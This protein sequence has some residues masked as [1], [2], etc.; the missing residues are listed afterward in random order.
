MKLSPEAQRIGQGEGQVISV[1]WNWV[2]IFGNGQCQSGTQRVVHLQESMVTE[3]YLP[4]ETLMSCNGQVPLAQEAVL[5]G[6]DPGRLNLKDSEP[7]IVFMGPI[8]T[9]WHTPGRA[10]EV[11]D[12]C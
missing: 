1:L 9:L 3:F 2:V 5:S 8:Q 7:A 12:P 4:L 11:C 6:E 10:E